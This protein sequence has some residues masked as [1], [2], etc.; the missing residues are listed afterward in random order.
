MSDTGKTKVS[1]LAFELGK[2]T[3]RAI[4]NTN[5]KAN[6][7]ELRKIAN[8]LLDAG[9]E[10]V[11]SDLLMLFVAGFEEGDPPERRTNPANRW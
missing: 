8:N 2:V 3:R 1:E 11:A 7:V 6:P 4:D 5:D 9:H 10:K